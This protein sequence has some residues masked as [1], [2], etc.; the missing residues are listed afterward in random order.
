VL[1]AGLMLT[2]AGPKVLEFNVR[3][4]DPEAEAVLPRLES[5][6]ADLLAAA[7]AGDLTR[8]GE[9]RFDDGACVTV[10]LASEGYP[11]RPR[12]GDVISG[13]DAAGAVAGVHVFHAGTALDA[14][15]R[16]VTAGGRV[17]AVTGRA[18]TLADARKAA[19]TGAA[20]I[21]WPGRQA[22]TDIALAAQE[23]P[24]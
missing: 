2:P 18:A 3:F 6:L 12:T 17:L 16:V 9:V 14:E 20:C 11:A 5:D 7:A 22:R 15:G 10:V 13:L 21:S 23:A 19:Y 24:V 4:G 8:A 1:Y